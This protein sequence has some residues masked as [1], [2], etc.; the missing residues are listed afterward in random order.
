MKVSG[1]TGKGAGMLTDEMLKL[2]QADRARE[3]AA[4]DRVRWLRSED[5][6]ETAGG[7]EESRLS[8]SAPATGRRAQTGTATDPA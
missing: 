5:A 4:A 1:D 2:I 7:F 6:A 3:I 8:V